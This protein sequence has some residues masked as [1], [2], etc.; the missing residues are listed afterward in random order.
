[1]P[2]TTYVL[3]LPTF[4]VFAIFVIERADGIDAD[5]F[6]VRDSFPSGSGPTPLIVPPVPMPQTKCV[7]FPSVSSQISGPVVAVVRLGI[8]RIFV[9]IGVEGIGNFAGEFFGHG[10]VAARIVGFDR[11][12]ADDHF[13]AE[14]LQQIDFFL[15]T[16]CR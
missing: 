16:A 5:D 4:P 12:G 13:G 15:A 14:G 2:S 10:I 6:Y 9:L 1:M 7:I 11:R 8:H 3:A